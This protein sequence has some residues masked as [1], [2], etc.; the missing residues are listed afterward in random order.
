MRKCS[1]WAAD[2][3]VG[4]KGNSCLPKHIHTNP[5]QISADISSGSSVWMS[6]AKFISNYYQGYTQVNTFYNPS[7][8]EYFY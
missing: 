5:C 8:D 6:L 4:E 2:Q 3:E 7:W 1:L